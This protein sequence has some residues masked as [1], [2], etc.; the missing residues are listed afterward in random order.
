MNISDQHFRQLLDR[1]LQGNATPEEIR[2]L[3]QFFDSYTHDLHEDISAADEET[4]VKILKSIQEQLHLDASQPVHRS[5]W[6]RIAAVFLLIALSIGVFYT[7]RSEKN[8]VAPPATTFLVEQ[9]PRG[10]KS[11][12][13][14]TDG[15]KVYLNSNTRMSYPN[16]FSG[17]QREVSLEGEAFFEVAHDASKPF[18]VKTA[19]STTQVLGTSF[20]VSAEENKNTA[21]TL[22]TGNVNVE[23]TQNK[24]N[25]TP[26]EQAIIDIQSKNLRTQSVDVE[27]IIAWKDNILV[28]KQTSLHEA[29]EKLEKWYDVDIEIP[30]SRLQ[31]C[32]I[33]GTYKN[34]SLDNVLNSFQFLLGV[35]IRQTGKKIT[36]TGSGCK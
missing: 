19:V 22:I 10:Q 25:L 5:Y 2:L 28:F 24:T 18:V 33:N 23:T 34:E 36:I 6:W 35:Q 12:V 14:L 16:K 1:Y 29:A 21:I 4:K 11:I 32:A 8:A 31:K 13:E 15:T 20:N 26:G 30:S 27:E 3:D 17:A 9:T 7:W